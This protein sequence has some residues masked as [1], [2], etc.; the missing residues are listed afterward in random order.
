MTSLA[1]AA[2]RTARQRLMQIAEPQDAVAIVLV[3]AFGPERALA[4]AEGRDRPSP[5][6]RREAAEA[7]PEYARSLTEEALEQA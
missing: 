1:P 5:A 6:E 4:I 2:V 3:A 7:W